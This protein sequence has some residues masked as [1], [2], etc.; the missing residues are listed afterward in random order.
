MSVCCDEC[1]ASFTTSDTIPYLDAGGQWWA[2]CPCCWAEVK[3]DP[4]IGAT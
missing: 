1:D 2:F 3:I 4:D